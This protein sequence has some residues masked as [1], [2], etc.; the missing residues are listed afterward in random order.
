MYHNITVIHRKC[1]IPGSRDHFLVKPHGFFFH[2][3]TASSLLKVDADGNVVDPGS[4]NFGLCKCTFKLHCEVH[5]SRPDVECVIHL[6]VPEAVSVSAT[7][8]GFL[9]VSQEAM[10]VGPVSDDGQDVDEEKSI[11]DSLGK[12]N[13]VLLRNHGFVVCGDTIEQTFL[14]TYFFIYNIKT[15]ARLINVQK[16]D[17]ILPNEETAKQIYH[18]LLNGELSGQ[19]T[20]NGRYPIHWP[21]GELDWEA[22]MRLLDNLGLKTGYKYRLPLWR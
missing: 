2:E 13:A 9:P 19:E 10:F 1:R 21:Q 22:Y 11:A 12:N 5:M 20:E 16:E 7:K 17:L 3:V 14:R 15:Q 6:H 18:K 8:N 4:S